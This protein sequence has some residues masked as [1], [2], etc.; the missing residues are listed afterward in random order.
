MT[1]QLNEQFIKDALK[2]QLHA[3]LD[4]LGESIEKCPE[5]LLYSGE[6]RNAVWQVAY[7]TLFFTHLYLCRRNEDFLPWEQ[8][9][10][11]NQNPDGIPG[12]SDP[13]SDLPLTPEPYTKE[14]LLEYTAYCKALVDPSVDGMDL[15]SEDSGFPWYKVPKFEHLLVNLRHIQ[16]GAAQ[17]ADRLRF[18][19][20]TGVSWAGKRKTNRT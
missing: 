13:A 6:Y 20:D 5:S 4:M 10:A 3:S 18:R 14:Q 15:A 19:L 11:D 12:D 16:H 7:H 1:A 9:Q 2:S 8:H 17:I